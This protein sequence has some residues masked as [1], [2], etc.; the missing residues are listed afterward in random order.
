MHLFAVTFHVKFQGFCFYRDY[1]RIMCSFIGMAIRVRV[2]DTRR[3]P[4]GY[5]YGDDFLSVGVTCTRPEPRRVRE[6][7]FF[8][9]A[10]NPTSTRY[11]TIAI[12]LGCEQVKMCSFCYIN[13][14]L[15]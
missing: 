3:V 15:F 6:V 13:Y 9:L 14:D 8:L 4:D 12:I 7:Y 2:P 1:V 11:Y 10:G 5:G